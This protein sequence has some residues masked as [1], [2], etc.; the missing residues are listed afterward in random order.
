MR[1]FPINKQP[2]FFFET[3]LEDQR[4]P[5]T[6]DDAFNSAIE[7]VL[8]EEKITFSVSVDLRL[9][10]DQTMKQI[11]QSYRQVNKPTNV[12]SFAL[13]EGESL[14]MQAMVAENDASMV[15]PLGELL[16]AF[17]TVEREAKEQACSF[18]DHVI[19]LVV[20]GL[21]HLLGYD[22]ERGEEDAIAQEEKEILILAQLGI[23]NPYA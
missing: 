5:D 2:P 13:W 1:I 21:L 11:N 15:I 23:K 9:I 8:L 14:M 12:L 19:H 22:H 10:D 6:L 3:A 20:H 18:K 4:W 16:L 17:E 7:A